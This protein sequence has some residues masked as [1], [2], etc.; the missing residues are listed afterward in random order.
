[1]N[2]KLDVIHTCN[3]LRSLVKAM[4]VPAELPRIYAT[5]KVLCD[6]LEQRAIFE[7]KWDGACKE[8]L[9]K[10]LIA[11]SVQAGLA[12]SN[13]DEP[14]AIALKEINAFEQSY[15]YPSSRDTQ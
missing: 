6:G 4:T 11:C 3:V 1:M 13:R 9:T 7:C 12:G 8:A 2:V 5:I 10:F 15:V 14:V